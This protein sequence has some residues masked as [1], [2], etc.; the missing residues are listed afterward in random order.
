MLSRTAE[1]E[2][3]QTGDNITVCLLITAV[4]MLLMSNHPTLLQQVCKLNHYNQVFKQLYL[5]M[6]H[7]VGRARLLELVTS[8]VSH[9]TLRRETRAQ[10]HRL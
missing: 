8:L 4:V 5:K 9:Q 1:D 10:S 6:F 2:G 3:Q 7:T